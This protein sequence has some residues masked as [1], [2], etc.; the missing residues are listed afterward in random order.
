MAE[1][2]GKNGNGNGKQVPL[3]I[4]VLLISGVFAWVGYSVIE[5]GKMLQ[6][7]DQKF[8]ELDKQND[9]TFADIRDKTKEIVPRSENERRW[10]SLEKSSE[11]NKERINQLERIV[12]SLATNGK[13]P[14]NYGGMQQ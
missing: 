1:E 5:Q 10:E 3:N 14:A 7:H 13:I 12:Y 2:N 11:N 6:R 4:L 9:S 8:V